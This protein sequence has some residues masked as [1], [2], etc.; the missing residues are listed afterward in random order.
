MPLPTTTSRALRVLL[1]EDKPVNQRLAV[2]LLEKEGH[3]PVVVNNGQEALAALKNQCFDLVLMDVQMP[4]L[5]GLEATALLRAREQ[6]DG[7]HIPIIA[8]TAHA[9]KGDEERCH[10]AGMDGYVC[11]PVQVAKLRAAIAA[12]LPDHFEDAA[13]VSTGEREPV[14]DA[15]AVLEALDGDESVLQELIELFLADASQHRRRM[16]L[17]LS[18]HDAEALRET[19]HTLKGAI[20]VF[21]VAAG[22][23]LG[24]RI[25]RLAAAG[26]FAGAAATFAELEQLLDQLQDEL[27]SFQT[28]RG[29][30]LVSV[31]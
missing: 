19:A 21:Q 18:E 29:R 17:A 16:Q 26:D 12:V 2:R 3:T 1:A 9:M 25:E 28:T 27:R 31:P 20:S 4:V 10:A 14:F 7:G 13:T 6:Q 30:A 24:E 22:V 8:M 5:G 15:S 23:K 11:K